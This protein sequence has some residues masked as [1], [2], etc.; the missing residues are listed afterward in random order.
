[1][2]IKN[3]PESVGHF[4]V[5]K[6]AF[7]SN[8]FLGWDDNNSEVNNVVIAT[9][10]TAGEAIPMTNKEE[11]M[12]VLLG[13][14]ATAG[15]DA[16]ALGLTFCEIPAGE[17]EVGDS[18]YDDN[19]V[20]HVQLDS[21]GLA[22]SSTT[23]KQLASGLRQLG[24]QNTV[25]MFEAVRDRRWSIVAR[26]TKEEVAAVKVEIGRLKEVDER[27]SI[28]TSAQVYK[29]EGHS[30]KG[31]PSFVLTSK[32][33]QQIVLKRHLSEKRHLRGFYG[34]AQPALITPFEAS[35]FAALFGFD[36]PRGDQWEVASGDLRDPKYQD[37]KELMKV[38]HCLLASETAD[39]KTYS[40]N[41]FGL[42]D[43]LGNVFEA[44]ANRFPDSRGHREIRGG[45]WNSPYTVIPFFRVSAFLR[46]T[47]PCPYP[48]D[49]WSSNVGFR[50]LRPQ[51]SSK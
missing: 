40:P 42:Y 25:L 17:Y 31:K 19:P 12:S 35:A 27:M 47:F 37:Q 11:T 4:L 18:D 50:L 14:E 3:L 21:F 9:P 46:P 30:P 44:M 45:A 23:N 20:R 51:A 15:L 28:V 24:K 26:G 6:S 16:S 36:L 7:L 13:L 43:M 29:M 1:M 22:E 38:A 39:V 48:P 34:N 33:L 41:Q 8:F 2:S 32:P 10:P 49:L 5:K